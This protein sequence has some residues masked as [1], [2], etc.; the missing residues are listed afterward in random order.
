MIIHITIIYL[1]YHLKF[2]IDIFEK[3]EKNYFNNINNLIIEM[4]I[5]INIINLMISI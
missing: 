2:Y 4:M 1:Y 5:R 3:K